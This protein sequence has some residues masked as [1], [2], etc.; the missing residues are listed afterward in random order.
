[1]SV[2]KDSDAVAASKLNEEPKGSLNLFH[3]LWMSPEEDK[4]W[5]AM[6]AKEEIKAERVDGYSEEERLAYRLG[7][8]EGLWF[9]AL[10]LLKAALESASSPSALIAAVE[11]EV[12]QKWMKLRARRVKLGMKM[13][14]PYP[15]SS[16][17]NKDFADED[18]ILLTQMTELKWFLNL[19]RGPPTE[20]AER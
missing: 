20:E 15:A 16:G 19:L 13:A 3:D 18:K 12:G 11:A 17:I 9:I 10:P 7:V 1:M 6:G 2:R 14:I 5:C 4:L 8:D